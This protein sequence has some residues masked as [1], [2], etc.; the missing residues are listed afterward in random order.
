MP[1]SRQSIEMSREFFAD[2]Y[3]YGPFDQTHD[4]KDI[5]GC[6]EPRD[7]ANTP[8]GEYKTI[9]QTGGGKIGEGFDAAMALTVEEDELV[10][11]ET[12]MERDIEQRPL[13]WSFAHY[14][15]KFV[16]GLV[17]IAEEIVDPSDFTLHSFEQW[18]R[19]FNEQ[20]VVQGRA[21]RI[22]DAAYRQIEYLQDKEHMDDLLHHADQIEPHEENVV[23]VLGENIARVYVTNLHPNRGK[24]R[25]KKP[26]DP[27]EAASIQAYHDSLAA[28]VNNLRGANLDKE[29]KNLRLTS[30][31]M[32]S[33]AV[34]TVISRDIMPEMTFY[35]AL[36]AD[37]RNG[38][39][40][41]EQRFA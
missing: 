26:S 11:V 31:L 22:K 9:I 16:G 39:E 19:H 40:V 3:N 30:M 10:T 25:N 20:D 34:R 24:D 5:I 17:L 29:I 12:G 41:I 28:T 35:E 18:A 15:C 1:V 6:I 27:V 37:A 38:L 33:A 14:R 21:G 7:Q 32:R 8:H 2:P 36:P 13:T 23:H 4:G